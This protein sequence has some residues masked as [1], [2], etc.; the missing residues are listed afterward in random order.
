MASNE[1]LSRR[2]LLKKW[3]LGAA[4]APLVTAGLSTSYAADVPLL[5]ADDATAKTLKYTD[6]AS[7]AKGVPA[8]NKCG[9]CAL[10][11]GSYGSSQGPCQ[12]FPGKQVKAAGWCSSWAPQI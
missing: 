4:V 6:D 9:N 2:N 10:Y 12:I 7:K 11:Q 3:L 5:S 1:N 8:D